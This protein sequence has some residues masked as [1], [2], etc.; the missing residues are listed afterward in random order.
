MPVP[1]DP[2]VA[3][4]KQEGAGNAK[5]CEDSWRLL[6]VLDYHVRISCGK[7][8]HQLTGHGLSVLE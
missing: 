6:T 7:D 1:A 8:A 5:L 2:L 3:V 4:C